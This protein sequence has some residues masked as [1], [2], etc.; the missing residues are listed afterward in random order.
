[1]KGTVKFYNAEKGFGFITDEQGNDHYIDRGIGEKL[2][3]T[4]G[5]KIEFDEVQKKNG[6][7]QVTKASLSNEEPKREE[8]PT[9]NEEKHGP[10]QTQAKKNDELEIHYSKEAINRE[11]DDNIKKRAKKNNKLMEFLKN[12]GNKLKKIGNIVLKPVVWAMDTISVI[13]MPKEVKK[14]IYNDALEQARQEVKQD[15][16][17]SLKEKAQTTLKKNNIVRSEEK[18]VNKLLSL[19]ELAYKTKQQVLVA[20]QKGAFMFERVDDTVL[21]KH[22]NPVRR[23][24]ESQKVTYGFKTISAVEFN[25]IGGIKKHLDLDLAMQQ[26]RMDGS[27]N[28]QNPDVSDNVVIENANNYG[29]DTE[30]ENPV[31]IKNV[32][33][34]ILTGDRDTIREA[35]LQSTDVPDYATQDENVESQN[36][37]ENYRGTQEQECDFANNNTGMAASDEW[38]REYEE[39][40][41][42]Y[43]QEQ[44]GFVQ[45]PFP[46]GYN[47]QE[48]QPF[49]FPQA[50]DIN[51]QSTPVQTTSYQQEDID[52]IM[53]RNKSPQTTTPETLEPERIIE[54]DMMH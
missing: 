48:Q 27:F 46:C 26:L 2:G 51:M 40:I 13:A 8:P 28:K 23:T 33:E 11:I 34:A 36:F 24:A 41:A 39:A 20:T 29:V 49:P 31:D 43:Q 30:I 1:M 4:Q 21:V 38:T 32:D 35:V 42:R 7:M 50:N 6:K 44:Q 47:M 37:E 3:L 25:K 52:D 19:A 53:T 17:N 15:R 54:D 5:Q 18:D 14:Q 12:I 22:A 9:Q 16:E 10:T 45:Q